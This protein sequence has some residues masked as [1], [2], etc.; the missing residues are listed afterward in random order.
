LMM[1][2]IWLH[3]GFA[4]IVGLRVGLISMC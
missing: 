3:V 2:M 1:I 4:D